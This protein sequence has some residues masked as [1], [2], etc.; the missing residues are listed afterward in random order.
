MRS[1]AKLPF[2]IPAF[3]VVGGMRLYLVCLAGFGQKERGSP[4][5][6]LDPSH[7]M[8]FLFMDLLSPHAIMVMRVLMS[9]CICEGFRPGKNN[10]GL[11]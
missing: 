11:G 2:I 9:V 10:E 4:L 8:S 6:I 7:S 3:A 1:N 5:D